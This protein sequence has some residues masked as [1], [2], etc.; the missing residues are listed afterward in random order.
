L[1]LSEATLGKA[2]KNLDPS[3][4]SLFL[5]AKQLRAILDSFTY[6][7]NPG[8]DKCAMIKEMHANDLMSGVSTMDF[9]DL[10]TVMT[11]VGK[12]EEKAS[13]KI[14]AAL[15]EVKIEDNAEEPKAKAVEV[16]AEKAVEKPV[17]EKKEAADE[18]YGEYDEEEAKDD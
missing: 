8:E 6:T 1:S 4:P 16:S 18:E 2:F 17:D 7:L 9:D 3:E 13:L 11:V 12:K 5:K 15:A 14:K 10:A